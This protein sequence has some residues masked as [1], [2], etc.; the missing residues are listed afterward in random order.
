LE[1]SDSQVWYSCGE[2]QEYSGPLGVSIQRTHRACFLLNLHDFLEPWDFYV[3]S[4]YCFMYHGL[5]VI[6]AMTN[7]LVFRVLF[8]YSDS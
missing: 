8:I 7:A 3:E 4:P 6:Y 2:V 5:D 1:A